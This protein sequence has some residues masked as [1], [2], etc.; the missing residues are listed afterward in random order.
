VDVQFLAQGSGDV[1][2]AVGNDMDLSHLL[3]RR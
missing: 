3:L 2:I 1:A